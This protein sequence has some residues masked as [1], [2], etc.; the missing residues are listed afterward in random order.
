MGFF[1]A[2]LSLILA[3]LSTKES[4]EA[5][6]FVALT[7]NS[8]IQSLVLEG[9]AH[10]LESVLLQ[11][12]MKQNP[13]LQPALL[14]QS[15]GHLVPGLSAVILVNHLLSFD[16]AKER[17]AAAQQMVENGVFRKFGITGKIAPALIQF[18]LGDSNEKNTHN[19]DQI[20]TR[21]RA[22]LVQIGTKNL[23]QLER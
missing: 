6:S 10:G 5:R 13:S 16:L 20:L 8:Q 7:Q 3:S 15:V 12:A 23:Q 11:V 22:R 2:C 17:N 9:D 19:S 18:A 4:V 14:V 21:E 1:I